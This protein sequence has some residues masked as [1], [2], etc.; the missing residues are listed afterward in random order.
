MSPEQIKNASVND[1]A[2]WMANALATT[3]CIGHTKGNWNETFAAKY[4]AELIE[5]GHDIPSIEL[6][7]GDRA[8][9][10]KMSALGTYNGPG[11][12]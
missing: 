7:G 6:F 11:S 12:L 2:E 8:Y 1:L 10:D 3:A 5:R 4:R 9:R